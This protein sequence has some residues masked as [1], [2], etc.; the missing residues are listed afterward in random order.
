MSMDPRLRS[1]ALVA[2]FGFAAILVFPAVFAPQA[3]ATHQP[4][5]KMAVSGSTVEFITTPLLGGAE[6]TTVE[7]LSG[8]LKTS[9]PT[10]LVLSVTLECA[11]WT[12]ITTIGNDESEAV[13]RVKVWVEIDGV[14]VGV[15]G[16]DTGDDAGKVVFCD[17]AYKRTTTDFDDDDARIDS[18]LRT[19]SAHAF[20]WIDLDL[21]SGLHTVVVKGQLDTAVTGT[22]MAQ[23]A[24][25]KR[26]LVVEPT[27]LA[28]DVEL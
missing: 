16:E 18:Y 21:G 2:A 6:S 1:V 14:P 25:G 23:A 9:S 13:A 8:Q 26:T 5:D 22:G 3:E 4:A 19:R 11:L 27:K 12:D 10:D 17:R 7:L 15:N 20:N 24:I 28:N